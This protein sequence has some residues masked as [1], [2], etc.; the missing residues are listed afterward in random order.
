MRLSYVVRAI[1]L[2]F[3]RVVYE[4][5]AWDETLVQW[6]EESG[7]LALI[8]YFA[9]LCVWITRGILWLFMVIGHALS[10]FLLRQ[11]EYDADRYEDRLAGSRTF[12]ETTRRLR[13]LN[14]AAE[15]AYASLPAFWI[16]GKYPN[17]FP[18][19]IREMAE[20]IPPK[21]RQRLEK[22]LRKTKTG[23]FDT[24]PSERDR[25]ASIEKEDAEGIFHLDQPATMLFSD[26]PRLAEDAS[27]RFYRKL[28][29]ER[30]QRSD[31]FAVG[32]ALP[33]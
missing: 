28:F 8:F 7:R 14:L 2:W 24:H 26:F 15:G 30:V 16:K 10:C 13:I 5:D 22:E 27:L 23:L 11:M 3:Y 21:R 32:D 1:N 4:R 12:A 31:L 9:R 33:G 17:S 25:L 18:A 20:Q 6:C 19:F 29:G